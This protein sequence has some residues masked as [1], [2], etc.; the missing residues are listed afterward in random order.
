[1]QYAAETSAKLVVKM[2]ELLAEEK[3]PY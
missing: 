3:K 1:L 2:V